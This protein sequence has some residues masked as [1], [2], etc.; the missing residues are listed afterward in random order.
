MDI[1]RP[2][3]KATGQRKYLLLAINYFTKWIEAEAVA[4]ITTAEVRRFIWKNIITRFGIPLTIIFDNGRQFDTAKLTDYLG[5]LGCQAQFTAVAHPQTN[6]QAEVANKF[7]L[8]LMMPKENG[9]TS[10]MVSYGPYEPLR[11]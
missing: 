3:S 1:L 4:S 6:S 10:Y 8:H 7:V 9:K 11:K 5:I 2:F